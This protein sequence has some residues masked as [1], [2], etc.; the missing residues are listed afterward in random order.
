MRRP[1]TSRVVWR[2]TWRI[3]AAR[4]PP[5]AL[6]E[7]IADP[8]DWEALLEVESL[9]NERLRDEVGEIRLVAPEERVSGPGASWVMGAF[10]HIGWPSRFSDGSYGVYYT[11]DSRDCAVSE[12]AFHLGRFLAATAEPPCDVA[13]RVLVAGIDA[14]LHDIRV[15]GGRFAREHDAK[16]WAAGQALGR[17]LRAAG[18]SG[19]VYRSVRH[20]GGECIAAFRPRVVKRLPR[21]D[22]HLRYHWDGSRVDRYWDFAAGRWHVL[23]PLP[24]PAALGGRRGVIEQSEPRTK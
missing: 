7:R 9:T 18:S 24:V 21:G 12:S 6:F 22:R 4:Y 15:R 5:V 1:P 14:V 13:M 10:T 2:R 3:I 20:A 17:V 19:V 23:A 16:D 8:A 11:A